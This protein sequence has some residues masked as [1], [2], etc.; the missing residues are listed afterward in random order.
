MNAITEQLGWMLLH[1]LWEGGAVWLLLQVVL[2][3]LQKKSAHSRYLAA[4]FALA[5]MALLPWMTFG[6]MDLSARLR[7][8]PMGSVPTLVHSEDGSSPSAAAVSSDVASSPSAAGSLEA[9]ILPTPQKTF[10]DAFLPWLVCGWG[11]GVAVFACR[12]WI[13]WRFVR[14][15]SRM[16]LLELSAAWQRR[17]GEL[18][19]TAG[20]RSIVRAGETAAVV[21]PLVVGWL[22]PV[23]LLPLGVLAQLP[24][25]Q[26]E[27]VLLHELAHIRRH[28]FLVNL[29]Q[30]V[31]ETV[32]FYHPAVRSISR[33]IREERELVCDDLSVEWC[34]NPV[35]YAEA[36]TTFEEF[37]RQSLTLAITG[38]GDLLARVRRIVLGIEPR[39]RTASLIAVASFLA[40]G[41]YLASMFLAPL[42]AA[43]LMTDKERVA[44]IESLQPPTNPA[45]SFEP[46]EN[47]FV[48]GTLSTEDGQPLPKSLFATEQTLKQSEAKVTSSH[49]PVWSGGALTMD[50][51]RSQTYYGNTQTGRIELG[52]WA[53]GYAPLRKTVLQS[54][55]GRVKVD[56]NLMRGF[57]ARVQVIGV[58]GRAVKGATL[59]ATSIHGD[60]YPLEISMPVVQTDETGLATFGNV[61]ED[62]EIHLNAFKAGWQMANETVS[63]WS[64][65]TPFVCK[66]DRAQSTSGL[67]IDQL[68][69]QPIVGA[70]IILAARR[71]AGDSYVTF[72]PENGQA[73]GHSDEKGRF[74]LDNLAQNPGYY[75]YVQADGYLTQS[76]PIDYGQ[77]NR[78]CELS[79]GLHIHGKILNS[80]GFLEKYHLPIELQVM[81]D[82]QATPFNGYGRE[83]RELLKLGPEIPFS[84]DGLPKGRTAIAFADFG[85]ESYR[86]E[87]DLQKNI[88]DYVIDLSKSPVWRDI[89]D[90]RPLRTFEVSLKTDSDA[91]P[92]GFLDGDYLSSKGEEKWRTPKVAK[93]TGG[94]ATMSLPVPTKV[95]LY[96]DHLVGYW[97]AP[98]SFDLP[99]GSATFLRTINAT[100]AGVIHGTLNPS[101]DIENQ[102]LSVLPIVIRPPSGLTITD[103]TSGTF[104][105]LSPKNDYVTQPVPFGGTYA[106]VVDAAPSYFVSASALVDAGQPIVVRDL[107]LKLPGGSLK[108]QFVDEANKPISYQEV[109]LTYHPDENDAFVSHSATTGADGTFTISN[110]N[111]NVPGN[112]EVQLYGNGWGQNKVRID[113][114]TPQPVIIS[115]HNQAK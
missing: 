51:P 11:L 92:T 87:I 43:E 15:L 35:V 47:V 31:V 71:G 108:G 96:A 21:V 40:T 33:R 82:L 17:L 106:V 97:F 62:S 79:R 4:C 49:G 56:L 85:L 30:S 64:K 8:V 69:R 52:V 90:P 2:I 32:F 57:P 105:A 10:V 36:L 94:K 60:N 29:L 76:F 99:V 112:Y 14:R 12:L 9:F 53:E 6:S 20:V 34:R 81:N 109:M 41:I 114:H 55:G 89:P 70:E 86:Y 78:V 107:A 73:L 102:S 50:N 80:R 45:N 37:R 1:S 84:F 67:V 74:N 59:S 54:H 101:P 44:K 24:A 72:A 23:I 61:E 95:G 22:K 104:K 38:E 58:D 68:T 26:V 75:I 77:L 83:K 16:P 3:I 42:L 7:S 93:I 63:Q 113:G 48:T 91:L 19:R 66:L 28:D 100:R 110:I 88:D 39:Q 46:S 65:Q 5:A 13:S 27:A 18:C 25:E 115:V 103:L 98:E 111:F